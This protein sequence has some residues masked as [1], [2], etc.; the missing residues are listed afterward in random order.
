[1]QDAFYTRLSFDRLHIDYLH[2]QT[3]E[4][5]ML[6]GNVLTGEETSVH[7]SHALIS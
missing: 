7:H 6:I 4:L 3:S 2:E 1:M 5:K